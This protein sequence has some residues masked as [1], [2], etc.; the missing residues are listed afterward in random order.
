MTI[1]CRPQSLTDCAQIAETLSGVLGRT[2]QHVK[3]NEQG[4]I[5]GLVQAG[6]SDYYA[7]FLTRLELL[8]SNNF[9]VATSDVVQGLTGHPPKSF[10]EFAEENKSAWSA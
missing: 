8:A 5:D 9:E 7:R 1:I 4:R 10:K 3:L 6:V 2:I